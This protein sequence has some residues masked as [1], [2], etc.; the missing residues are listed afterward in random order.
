M[1]LPDTM[2]YVELNEKYN[3]REKESEGD[4]NGVKMPIFYNNVYK[5]PYNGAKPG[6]MGNISF[7]TRNR[8]IYL[9]MLG[10][11]YGSTGPNKDFC[12]LNRVKMLIF[13]NNVCKTP[14][15]DT[16]PGVIRKISLQATNGKIYVTISNNRYGSTGTKMYFCV[17]KVITMPMFYNNVCK[18][19]YNGTKPGLMGNISFQTR[20]R[21]IYL[22]ILYN[23]YGSAGPKRSFCVLKGIKKPIFYNNVY[24][25]PYNDTK[26]G[27]IREISFQATNGKIYVTISNNRYGSTGTKMYFCVLKVITMPMFY[28]NVCKTPYNG[29]KPGLMGNISFQTRN[30]KIYLTMLGNSYGSTGRNKDFWVLKWVKMPIFYN[31]VYKTPYNGTKPGLIGNISFQTRNRKIYL[32]MLGNSYGSTG[33]NKDFWVLNR[34]KMPIFYNNVCKTPYNDTKPG[35]IR[36]ISLQATNGKIY[37]TISNNRYGSTGTKMYFCVLKVITM[38]MFY[39]NVCKTPYNGAKPGLMGNISFQ[40]RNRKIYLT[41]LGNS[42]GSTGPNKDF[43]VLNRVKM[44]IFDNNVCKTP[45]NDTKPGV[46]RK[47]SLQATNGK[48]YV[49]ISNNRYGSTGTKMYFCVLKVITMPMF[50]NNVCKTPYNGTKPCLMGNISFQTRNRKIY[51]TILYNRYGSAGPKRS[52]CVLKGIKK[53]IFYNN[54]YKT[55]YNDTKPGVIRE[56]SFQ[57]TN[58]KIYVTISNNRYGSTGTKMYFCVLKV[59]T[60]PM[61]YNNVCKTPYNGTK[62]GLMGNISFQ[63]RNRKI[64]LTMLGNSYGSTGRNKD[65]WVLKWV[66]MPIFYNNVY[67]TPYNGTKP[68]LIGNI[69]FQ[70]RNRK[71]YLTMLGNSY[72]STGPNK[73]FWVLNRVKMPIF[74]NNVYKTPYNGTKPDLMGNISF[75]TRNRKIYLTMLG[76]SYGS[77]GP[78]KDF[79]VL[80]RVKMPIFYNNV[81]KTPYNGRKPGVIRKYIVPGDKWEDICDHARTIGMDLLVQRRYFCVPKGD[82]NAYVLQ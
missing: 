78:N 80:N 82:H 37:V 69:S 71:I 49:T 54:V 60:M 81:Y 79:W 29:T 55:P 74:Y 48:I 11:S 30:R 39:N 14:Y 31:N 16:K 65:F 42:Y 27:V 15:N 59:I 33:P 12:V 22:T 53:P 56:I 63:T 5:T 66:K 35:V 64:Y 24:K 44:L 38:P 40:T 25:T 36:K 43:C 8:K 47:I 18:T 45:Y 75:Q 57:A 34:V 32:T 4:Q 10:N 73:D 28:N 46:I 50:Y 62:P 68:G 23:R 58:G 51:L 61:F 13:D 3:R 72:G 76:N 7:Q 1:Y 70:T 20:N 2:N 26:P 77:T 52:F 21:K 67:K 19:P 9:T 6:L 17:L 41:M